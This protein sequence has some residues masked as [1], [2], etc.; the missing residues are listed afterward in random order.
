MYSTISEKS[1]S[2]W[3]LPDAIAGAVAID[4]EFYIGYMGPLVSLEVSMH[5][6]PL[7]NNLVTSDEA[8]TTS[9]L[10]RH[11][12]EDSPGIAGCYTILEAWYALMPTG[13]QLEELASYTRTM[14]RA[15]F[16]VEGCF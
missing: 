1:W 5:Q 8:K 14:R 4:L 13:A 11:G 7:P 3:L 16:I 10:V 6:T 2:N 12:V 9:F 15:P